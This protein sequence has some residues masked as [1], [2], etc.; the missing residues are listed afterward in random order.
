MNCYKLLGIIFG[1]YNKE[2]TKINTVITLT[3]KQIKPI[4]NSRVY[5]IV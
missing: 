4:K 1:V 3:Q 5:P 2:L